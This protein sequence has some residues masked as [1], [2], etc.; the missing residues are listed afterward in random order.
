[1]RI[2]SAL[3]PPLGKQRLD[4]SL[5]MLIQQ[6]SV[7]MSVFLATYRLGLRLDVDQGFQNF[8]ELTGIFL[9]ARFI[10]RSEDDVSDSLRKLDVAHPFP[11]RVSLCRRIFVDEVVVAV[12]RLAR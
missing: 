8:L 11:L 10:A 4:L 12:L 7:T 6:L 3:L 5:R 2:G 1:V 9:V